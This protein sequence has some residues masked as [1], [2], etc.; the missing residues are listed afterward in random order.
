MEFPGGPL[1]LV[2]LEGPSRSWRS[3]AWPNGADRGV[4]GIPWGLSREARAIEGGAAKAAAD[5][6]AGM[7]VSSPLP[8]PAATNV[9]RETAL[10]P[11]PE[12]WPTVAGRN[13]G[14]VST[15]TGGE[16]DPEVA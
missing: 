5:A 16:V 1:P 9:I 3:A 4:D 11:I 2:P 14:S 7:G 6:A 12:D 8:A 10:P 15:A 13:N